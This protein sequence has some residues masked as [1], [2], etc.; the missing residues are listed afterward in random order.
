MTQIDNRSRIILRSLGEDGLPPTAPGITLLAIMDAP[1]N[2]WL[3]RTAAG[4]L[5]C[6]TGN[7][8]ASVDPRKASAAMAE[9]AGSGDDG[10]DVDPDELARVVK[11]WR[12]TMTTKKAAAQIGISPRTLEGIEQGRG[13]RYPRL[14]QLAL[15]AVE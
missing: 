2:G 1:R 13:F 7:S 8:I 10:S 3:A 14:L 5:V 9:L 4:A 15:K 11:A 6:W 12:G